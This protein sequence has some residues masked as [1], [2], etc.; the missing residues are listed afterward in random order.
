MPL[1]DYLS[2]SAGF[3]PAG[4]VAAQNRCY[5][6]LES[7]IAQLEKSQDSEDEQ[8]LLKIF[9]SLQSMVETAAGSARYARAKTFWTYWDRNK[10]SIISVVEDTDD[11]IAIEN[12]IGELEEG[13][14][15]AD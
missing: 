7:T 6:Y 9:K 15:Y 13:R 8:N 3:M 11:D 14:Y 4:D 1:Y 10:K 12:K 2:Y 5:K